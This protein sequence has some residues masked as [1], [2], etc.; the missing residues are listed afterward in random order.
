MFRRIFR[1][2][3]SVASF[4]MP[5][6]VKTKIK[7]NLDYAKFIVQ[8]EL[9]RPD[10]PNLG[11]ILNSFPVLSIL[12]PFVPSRS[13]ISSL[14]LNTSIESLSN[15]INPAYFSAFREQGSTIFHRLPLPSF[16]HS[17]LESATLFAARIVGSSIHDSGIVLEEEEVFIPNVEYL[18]VDGVRTEILAWHAKDEQNNDIDPHRVEKILLMVPGNPGVSHFYVDFLQ[19]VHT[20]LGSQIS[21][22]GVEHLGHSLGE[23]NTD[24]LYNLQDQIRH[25]MHLLDFFAAR[26]PS[27]QIYL[28]GHSV[29]A[30]I[31]VQLLKLRGEQ[32][33][34]RI[35]KVMLLFPTLMEI[36]NTPNGV[37][38]SH[39]TRS[40]PRQLAS[41]AATGLNRLNPKLLHFLVKV[42]SSQTDAQ[43]VITTSRLLHPKTVV[44]CLYMANYEMDEIK[45]LDADVIDKY[46]S[47]LIFY[48]GTTDKW[49]PLSH[50]EMTKKRWPKADI[51][52]CQD[53]F[54]HAFVLG[55]GEPMGQKVASWII[56]DSFNL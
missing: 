12:R 40:V 46:I 24:N 56:S 39:L 51:H 13:V 11:S 16:V 8:S 30:Y 31:C 29:G 10:F 52:L 25:K 1:L 45:K 35:G 53:S 36:K 9:H 5:H 14:N 20:E 41:V 4:L 2:T 44:N 28:A 32:Y 50:Y 37:W 21:I 15:K 55:H 47:K 33:Q 34:D 54:P 19:T 7:T 3:T 38:I 49:V 22:F 17:Y 48:Y 43:T 27:A 6:S 26:Y 42:L 18:N 23:H